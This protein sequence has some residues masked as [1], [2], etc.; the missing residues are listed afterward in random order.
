MLGLYIALAHLVGDYLIQSHWMA[1]EKTSKWL[2]AVAH[3]I[4]YTLAYMLLT[5][6]PWALLIIGGT[7]IIIDHYRLA[8][9]VVFIKNFL[10][11]RRTWPTWKDS[12][13]TGYPS[14][15]PDWLATWLMII[16]DN[17]LHLLI[18]VAVFVLIVGV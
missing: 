4:T 18:N 14:T 1:I 10:G 6:N 7:H 12:N 9:H 3:G 5:L 2:P 16:G 15:T 17:T 11:P 13:K 8:R